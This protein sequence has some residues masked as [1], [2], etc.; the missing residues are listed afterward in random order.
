M[1]ICYD[2]LEKLRYV[3]ED[4]VWKNEYHQIMLYMDRCKNCGEDYFTLRKSIEDGNGLFCSRECGHRFKYESTFDR[5][6]KD[7]KFNHLTIIELA[8]RYNNGTYIAL[9]RCDCGNTHTASVYHLKHGKI[10]SCGCL[11]RDM[12]RGDTNPL[13]KGG[14]T[15]KNIALYDTY[16]PQLFCDKVGFTIEDGIKKLTVSCSY[17]GRM[18]SPSMDEVSRR[19]KSINNVDK[20]NS[21]FYCTDDCKKNCSSFAKKLYPSGYKVATSRE[22]NP[23]LRKLCFDRDGFMCIKCKAKENLHCHHILG[24]TQYKLLSNDID[25]V[26]TVCASC[27][28]KIHAQDGCKYNDLK[29]KEKV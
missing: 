26:I 7:K 1:K 22:V 14:V 25:N 9:C 5:N 29:C 24:A 8:Y 16:A 23:L 11:I 27:H 17:C 10:K 13:Y 6:W 21:A 2:T 4:G 18:Y 15:K 20:G 3:K 28:K 12:M 19:V